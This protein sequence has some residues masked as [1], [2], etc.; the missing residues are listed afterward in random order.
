LNGI[1]RFKQGANLC[2]KIHVEK[3]TKTIRHKR[4]EISLGVARTVLKCWWSVVWTETL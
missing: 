4:D 2:S 1:K 3:T